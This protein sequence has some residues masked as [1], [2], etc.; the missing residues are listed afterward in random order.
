MS[1]DLDKQEREWINRKAAE[2]IAASGKSHG[3]GGDK[4]VYAEVEELYLKQREEMKRAQTRCDNPI[5][6]LNQGERESAQAA[7][8]KA[9][10]ALAVQAA[11]AQPGLGFGDIKRVT[12]EA[13]E[14]FA[15]EERFRKMRF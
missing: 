12:G 7:E 9:R 15:K 2:R 3:F 5:D 6:K 11:L 13:Q 8:A 4:H 14:R 10:L 1:R